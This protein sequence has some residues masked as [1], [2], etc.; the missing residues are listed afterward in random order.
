MLL[1]VGLAAPLL[2]YGIV[3]NV[4]LG[5][6]ARMAPAIQVF[7]IT[8]PLN[9]LLGLGLLAAVIGGMLRLF[10]EA[11]GNFVQSGWSF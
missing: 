2:V 8:Q 6:A 1:G 11:M 3:F 4:A 5:L 7:F 10:A 9:L